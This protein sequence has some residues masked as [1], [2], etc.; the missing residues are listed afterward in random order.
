METTYLREFAKVA[1]C[2]SFTAAAR[3]LHL[4]QSTLSKHVALLEREFGAD[5]FVRDRSGVSLTEAGGVL[6]AQAR[7]MEQLLRATVALVHAAR[8]GQAPGAGADA[9]AAGA[10]GVEA[11]DSARAGGGAASAGSRPSAAGSTG[12]SW[13]RSSCTWRSAAST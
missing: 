5:L 7:Q 3:T 10:T 12:A 6:Y 9:G 4:T 1:E 8:D 13:A 2:G 11:A